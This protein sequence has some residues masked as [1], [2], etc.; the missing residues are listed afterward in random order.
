VGAGVA[1]GVG[2]GVGTGVGVGVEVAAEAAVDPEAE[3]LPA[4]AGWLGDGA[5]GTLRVGLGAG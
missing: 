5:G 3:L 1:A 2:T 4:A